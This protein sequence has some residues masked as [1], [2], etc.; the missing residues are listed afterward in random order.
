MGFTGSGLEF[1][2]GRAMGLGTEVPQ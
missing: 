1:L 2:R